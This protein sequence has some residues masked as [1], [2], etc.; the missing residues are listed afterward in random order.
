MDKFFQAAK[1]KNGMYSFERECDLIWH[2]LD[3]ESQK[4]LLRCLELSTYKGDD[5]EVMKE[6]IALH[7]WQN[8]V[9]LDISLIPENEMKKVQNV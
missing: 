9:D 5:I 1:D 2:S 3:R 7:R 6:Y 8:E 4:K